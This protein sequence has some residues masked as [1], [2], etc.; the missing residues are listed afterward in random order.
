MKGQIEMEPAV[1]PTSRKAAKWVFD[2]GIRLGW[3][4]ATAHTPQHEP[5]YFLRANGNAGDNEPQLYAFRRSPAYL[6]YLA[7][8]GCTQIWF[9]WWKGF[10][11]NHERECMQQVAKLF[12]LC[13]K[14]GMRAI[15]YFSLG[16]LTPD[17]LL[18]EEPGAEDWFTVTQTGGRASCQVTHQCF[19][20]R[21]CYTSE[22]YLAYM[23]KVLGD[24][25]ASGADG[26]HFD[27][28]GMAAEP[29]ACHCPRCAKK[30]REY[31]Q[32]RYA[33][34]LGE[35]LFGMRDFTHATI[36]WFNQHNTANNLKR[37]AVPLQR[38]WIDFKC[39]AYAQA[40]ERLFDFIRSRKPD[41]FVE[42]NLMESD[43]FA[44]AFWRANDY[45]MLMPKLEMVCDEANGV[46]GLNARGAIIGAYRAKKWARAFGC[47]HNS[48]VKPR[49]LA[50][51]FAEELAFSNAPKA[52]WA[53]YRE[54][55]LK[56]VSLAQVAVLQEQLSLRYNRFDPLEETLAAEQYLIERR[57]PFD[58]VSNIHLE[59]LDA[60]Y[61]LLVVAGMEVISDALRDQLVAWVERGGN[62]LLTGR[63]GM[64]DEYCRLRRRHLN[65]VNTLADYK[66]ALRP[67]NAFQT[68]IGMD[69]HGEKSDFFVRGYGSGKVGWARAMDV[70]RTPR[71]A[72]NWWLS[73]DMLMMPRNARQL[74]EV[75]AGLIP[76]GGRLQVET[77]GRLYV[78]H[79]ART[80]TCEQMVHLIN[81]AFPEQ[82]AEAHVTLRIERPVKEVVSV[83]VDDA[84]SGY[85]LRQES[86]ELRDGRLHVRV[87]DI[88]NHR[89]L[90]IR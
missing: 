23:E 22:G 29:E 6:E 18:E 41:A 15:C 30:F 13:K 2:E 68:L 75:L 78:H 72:E 26:I 5:L 71:T 14:L 45:A 53:S 56:S 63:S 20:C 36:P 28:I 3:G 60:R 81:H 16:S 46:D 83:S 51:Q 33:G 66:E 19:R 61:K 47:A 74:D 17:T 69:P 1:N 57:V 27:N 76:D 37:A 67:C 79:S 80:D 31:L 8:L 73:H 84:E 4:S 85:A 39:E 70:D 64:Y 10:G 90:I 77:S 32:K 9:N 48:G 58:F 25:L 54:Y 42:M 86:F 11:L 38:A 7:S 89:S 12:P 55:Q 34:A 65:A 24:C 87:A 88:R 21:P 52:F 49:Q 59:N 44:G 35:E 40:S 50:S 62:L 82:V 43:G